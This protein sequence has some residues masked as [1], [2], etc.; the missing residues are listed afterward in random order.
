MLKGVGGAGVG[1]AFRLDAQVLN[2]FVVAGGRGPQGTYQVHYGAIEGEEQQEENDAG[3][4]ALGVDWDRRAEESG[5]TSKV[6]N[7][8]G[9]VCE[10][11]M[12]ASGGG[13]DVR[14]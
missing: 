1:T 10:G 14:H 7:K 5:L 11:M 13:D 2:G 6:G 12:A 4:I 8:C 3:N 9:R